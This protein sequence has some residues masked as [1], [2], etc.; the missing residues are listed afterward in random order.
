MEI[1]LNLFEWYPVCEII[2]CPISCKDFFSNKYSL[3]QVIYCTLKKIFIF[4]VL[5]KI[6]TKNNL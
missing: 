5:Q 2:L 6:I 4:N 1:L 3:S